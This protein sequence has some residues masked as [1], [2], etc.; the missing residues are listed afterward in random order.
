MTITIATACRRAWKS[1]RVEEIADVADGLR[2]SHGFDFAQVHA[3]FC[4]STGKD[5]SLATFDEIMRL[6]DDGY[7]GTLAELQR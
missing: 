1:A 6:V 4:E 7:T 3:M 2:L 5:I